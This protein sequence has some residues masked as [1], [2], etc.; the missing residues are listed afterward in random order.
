[1]QMMP[2]FLLTWKKHYNDSSPEFGLII[3]LK[4]TNIMGQDI[5]TKLCISISDYTV[6]VVDNFTYLTTTNPNNLCLSAELNVQIGKAAAATML[7]TNTKTVYQAYVLRTLL[8]GSESWTYLWHQLAGSRHKEQPCP[9]RI[10]KHVCN[11]DTETNALLGNGRRPYPKGCA[12]HLYQDE[13]DGHIQLQG[14][15]SQTQINYRRIIGA[16][17]RCLVR[18]KNAS[19]I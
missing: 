17:L 11:A 16:K 3:S 9:V 6:G 15:R 13:Q 14:R 2:P 8:Y 12:V 18:Q 19:N 7:T 10:A 5:S 4:K 1:M